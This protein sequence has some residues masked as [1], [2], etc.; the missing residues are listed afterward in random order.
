MC[1]PK[2]Y[3]ST[4]K[5][6]RLKTTLAL[7]PKFGFG[8]AAEVLRNAQDLNLLSKLINFLRSLPA[9]GQIVS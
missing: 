4:D 3:N 8:C 6:F 1:L 5:Y 9:G 7:S 2:D